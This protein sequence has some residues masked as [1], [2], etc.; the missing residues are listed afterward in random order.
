MF[1]PA[2]A[3]LADNR[4]PGHLHRWLRAWPITVTLGILAPVAAS[5]ADGRYPGHLSTGG[6][7]PGRWPLPWASAP[8]AASLAMDPD[9]WSGCTMPGKVC[10]SLGGLAALAGDGFQEPGPGNPAPWPK[11]GHF[12]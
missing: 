5:L 7:E 8:M 6:C 9:P 4:Y 11:L 12:A 1:F 2:A 10:L 3:S